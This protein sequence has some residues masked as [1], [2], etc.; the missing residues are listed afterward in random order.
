MA[1]S[2]P[3]A[4]AD[5]PKQEIGDF[6]PCVWGDFFVTYNPPLS[7][8]S[9]RSMRERA[10]QLK[11]Q[12]RALFENGNDRSVA[13]VVTLVETLERLGIDNHFHGEIGTALQHVLNEEPEFRASSSHDLHVAALRFRL[14][15]QHGFWVS[16]G[17]IYS[18]KFKL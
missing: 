4:T 11:D 18:L 3:A 1:A 2:K 16:A 6:E 8:S 5:P 7:Q 13:D 10:E 17:N 12:V 15:R 14:L 9:E